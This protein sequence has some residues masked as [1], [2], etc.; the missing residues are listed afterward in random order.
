MTS[1]TALLVDDIV[2]LSHYGSMARHVY[3]MRRYI[4]SVKIYSKNYSK[5]EYEF[6]CFMFLDYFLLL[7][8]SKCHCYGPLLVHFYVWW[9][10]GV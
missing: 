8:H 1:G 9:S 10:T 2:M 6:M 5:Y 3:T 4:D 7:T